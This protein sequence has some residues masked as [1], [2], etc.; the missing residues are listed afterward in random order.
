[1]AVGRKPLVRNRENARGCGESA[2]R[3]GRRA[4][5]SVLHQ[6]VRAAV[7]LGALVFSFPVSAEAAGDS[8]AYRLAPGD[9][10]AVLVFGQAEL[11]GDILVDGAGNILLPFIGPIE[12]KGLT[13]LECQK[14][15][16]DRLSDGILQE[17][18]VSVRISEPRPLYILG[19]VRAPGAYPF[20]Y[21]S[22][23]QSVVAVAGGFGLP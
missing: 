14:L 4:M 17:P 21:G 11:S 20:R 16:R 3:P 7:L 18:S 10:I 22:T 8:R 9:R 23:V 12:V 15:V 19:G 2:M 13:T 1:M 5:A 6:F